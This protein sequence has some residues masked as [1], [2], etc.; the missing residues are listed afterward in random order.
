MKSLWMY[1]LDLS[2]FND[3]LKCLSKQWVPAVTFQRMAF[4]PSIRLGWFGIPIALPWPTTYIKA[5]QSHHWKPR[6]ATK[7]GNFRLC[8][9]HYEGYSLGS[10]S[11]FRKF[12]LH[13][14]SIEPSK[15]LP[16]SAV[17]P[18]TLSFTCPPLY[19]IP[20][21]PFPILPSL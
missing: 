7:D 5:I 11:E 17:S 20:S 9:L 12:P 3:L 15:W 14:V 4:F 13:K 16:I 6:L 21:T 2:T 19:L 1:Q 8:I 10:P 18:H